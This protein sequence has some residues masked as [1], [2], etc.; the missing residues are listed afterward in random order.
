MLIAGKVDGEQG[1]I[2]GGAWRVLSRNDGVQ[3]RCSKLEH[4][5]QTVDS[6]NG[7]CGVI[8]NSKR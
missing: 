5:L 4:G 6:R 7:N 8:R 3:Q 1:V 2:S